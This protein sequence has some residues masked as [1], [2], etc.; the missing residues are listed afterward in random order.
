MNKS[1]TRYLQIKR[2]FEK[3]AAVF[4]KLFFKVA[5]RYEEMMCALIDALPFNKK[6]KLRVIDLGCGT[7][8]LSK[9][10][11]AAY[12]NA[13]ITCVDMAENMLAMAK[14]KLKEHRNITFWLGDV[15]KFDYREKYDVI[16]AS[17]VLHHVEA[18]DKLRFYRAIH[19]SLT[20]NGVFLCI[21]IFVSRNRHLQKL[22]ME[23]WKKFMSGQGLAKKKIDDMISRHQKEDRPVA[24]EDELAIMRGSGFR[25]VEVISK[26]YNFALYGGSR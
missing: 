21:D 24:L 18:K 1:Q 7:G 16:V 12:P 15:R 25:H 6:Q 20:Q 19:S 8:N 5:P 11:I 17:L 3:E 4:D 2:H 9:K 10:I 23:K 26:Y 22:H 14:S 13:C